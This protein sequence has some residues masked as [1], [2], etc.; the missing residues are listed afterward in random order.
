MI[1]EYIAFTVFEELIGYSGRET[2][3]ALSFISW[4]FR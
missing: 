2:N 3:A 1:G 4:F